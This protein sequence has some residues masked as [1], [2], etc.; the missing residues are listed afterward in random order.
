MLVDCGAR[1]RYVICGAR[2]RPVEKYEI[3]LIG[4]VW[5]RGELQNVIACF[6]MK[7]DLDCEVYWR[8]PSNSQ[9]ASVLMSGWRRGAGVSRKG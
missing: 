8:P 6:T 3:T 5:M 4:S 1:L 9:A 2:K 7:G